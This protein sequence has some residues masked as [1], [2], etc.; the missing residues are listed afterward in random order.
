M[1]TLKH[2][3]GLALCGVL[4]SLAP[5]LKSFDLYDVIFKVIRRSNGEK[6]LTKRFKNPFYIFLGSLILKPK[7]FVLYD[8]VI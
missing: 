1:F 5:N 8:K 3:A 4:G 7:F 2:K 6:A